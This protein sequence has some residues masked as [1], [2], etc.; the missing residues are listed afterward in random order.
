VIQKEVE[1]KISEL[2]LDGTMK[3]NKKYVISFKKDA[4]VVKN[5]K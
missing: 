5:E 1:T 2:I 3:E 4:L